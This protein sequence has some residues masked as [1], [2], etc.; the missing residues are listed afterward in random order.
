MSLDIEIFENENQIHCCNFYGFKN[1]N[2]ENRVELALKSGF[3]SVID[4][5]S[6]EIYINKYVCKDK[7]QFYINLIKNKNAKIKINIF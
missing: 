1:Y 3:E 4:F 2:S 7:R 5:W 6:Y